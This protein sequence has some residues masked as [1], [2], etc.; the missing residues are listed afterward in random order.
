MSREGR[1]QPIQPFATHGFVDPGPGPVGTT[2]PPVTVVPL[3]DERQRQRLTLPSIVISGALLSVTAP[4][5]FPPE[6]LIVP[7]AERRRSLEE[8]PTA[9]HGFELESPPEPTVAEP[10][11]RRRRFRLPLDPIVIS[12]V[13][14]GL[15]APSALPPPPNII[16]LNERGRFP[17]IPPATSIHGFSDP[18]PGPVGTTPPSATNVDRAD[19]RVRYKP[20]DP[21]VISGVL[22]GLPAPPPDTPPEPTVVDRGDQ[23][24]RYLPLAPIVL[25]AALLGVPTTPDVPPPPLIVPADERRRFLTFLAPQDAHGFDDIAPP[26]PNVSEP[27]R[28]RYPPLDSVTLNGE[29]AGLAPP[30]ATPPEPIIVEFVSARRRTPEAIS[31]SGVLAGLSITVDLPPSPT[32]VEPSDRR[33][34]PLLPPSITHSFADPGPGPVGTT[35]PPFTNLDRVDQ[36]KRYLPLDPL[37]L[38]GVLAATVPAAPVTILAGTDWASE[39]AMS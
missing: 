6:S 28:R 23:R 32:V 30:A 10:D 37:V 31:I 22:A 8:Q 35:P 20:L 25:S 27:Q 19:Q 21:I 26:P 34:L 5:I 9:A 4:T 18:G 17:V 13:Y 11:D 3:I 15:P 24:N 29:L 38:S 39:I 2:P 33:R 1:S 12:G 36:R 14:A 16:P 7:L